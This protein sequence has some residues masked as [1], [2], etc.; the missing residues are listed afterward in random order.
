MSP[1]KGM[2]NSWTSGFHIPFSS[3]GLALHY[4]IKYIRIFST[5]SVPIHSLTYYYLYSTSSSMRIGTVFI[6]KV[7]RSPNPTFQ[8]LLFLTPR[9]IWYCRFSLQPQTLLFWYH[10]LVGPCRHLSFLCHHFRQRQS[11]P[12]A[13]VPRC[14]HSR[15]RP[16]VAGDY[17]VA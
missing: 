5:S 4:L 6:N 3:N 2:F 13:W 11:E 8:S 7:H 17:T 9:C 12:C 1:L 15:V 16:F 14:H 10:T